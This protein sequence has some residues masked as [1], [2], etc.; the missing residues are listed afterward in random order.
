M[1]LAKLV[2]TFEFKGKTFNVYEYSPCFVALFGGYSRVVEMSE[3]EDKNY[4]TE[5]S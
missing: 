5:K 4:T 3:A 1:E 2:K